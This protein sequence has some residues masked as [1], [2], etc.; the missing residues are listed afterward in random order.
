M[1]LKSENILVNNQHYL[2]TFINNLPVSPLA[3]DPDF[4][5]VDA[6]GGWDGMGSPDTGRIFVSLTHT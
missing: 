6:T 1:Y 2:L 5:V 4:K 3:D